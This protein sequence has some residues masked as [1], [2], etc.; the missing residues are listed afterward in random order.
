MN[1]L[2]AR[3]IPFWGIDRLSEVEFRC[4]V[5]WRDLE[6]ASRV[7][8]SAQCAVEVERYVGLRQTLRGLKRRP[9]MV[10]G[11]VVVLAALVLLPRFV[12]TV[13]VQGNER[14]QTG[15]I[16]HAL[17]KFGVK[18]GAWGA[19]IRSQDIKNRMMNELPELRW[20]AVNRTGGCVTVLVAEREPE[21]QIE[22]EHEITNVV[23]SRAGVITQMQVMDGFKACEVGDTVTE[24]QL[25]VSGYADWTTGPQA[26]HALAEIYAMTW[27][28]ETVQ[29]PKTVRQKCYTGEEITNYI[30]IIGRKRINL[31]RNSGIPQGKCDKIVERKA[32]IL[33]GGYAFPA[34]LEIETLRS[35]QTQEVPL[36]RQEAE[37]LLLDYVT[38]TVKG[39]MIAGSI[40]SQSYTVTAKASTWLLEADNSC[41]EMIARMVP[42]PID[43]FG[44]TPET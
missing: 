44:E 35:Y 14:V 4:V 13:Q 5:Y 24:G 25:L 20:C 37:A 31:S 41:Q 28:H 9:V 23:A 11:M 18:F 26:V 40:L 15:E 12:W 21:P 19:D 32:L 33:P 30:L 34:E 2:A 6:E 43:L 17:E 38:R 16:L 10:V 39:D 8:G 29:I 42:A 22:L 3:R 7:A 27:R 36:T 1:R